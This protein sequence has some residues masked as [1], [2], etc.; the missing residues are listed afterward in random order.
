MERIKY[1]ESVGMIQRVI[2]D[3]DGKGPYWRLV[4]SPIREIKENKTGKHVKTKDRF[5]TLDAEEIEDTTETIENAEGYIIVHEPFLL[6]KR[7][8]IIAE[9]WV[10]WANEN[11]DK[12]T[13]LLTGE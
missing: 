11:P 3:K 4:E 10:K 2:C 1:G 12:A 9:R 5:Y 7:A 13:S 6:T 8:R